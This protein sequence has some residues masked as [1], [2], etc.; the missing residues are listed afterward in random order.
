MKDAH[1]AYKAAIRAIN[2]LPTGARTPEKIA[3]EIGHNIHRA[4]TGIIQ[5]YAE[6]YPQIDV[7]G[8][9]KEFTACEVGLQFNINV[10][11]N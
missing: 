2:E 8:V 3:V 5:E 10:P 4:V 7:Q 9:V 1:T 11:I 6:K